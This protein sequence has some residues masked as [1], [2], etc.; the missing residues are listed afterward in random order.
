MSIAVRYRHNPILSP[1]ASDWEARGAFN[2]TVI[3]GD[4]GFHMLYRA[5]STEHH[6]GEHT[7]E[8]SSIGHAI[9][10]DRVHFLNKRQLIVPSESWDLFGC[11]DP[12]VTRIESTYY[13]SYTALSA[14]PPHPRGVSVGLATTKDFFSLENKFHLTPFNSKAFT[15]FPEKIRGS[16]AALLTANCDI[17]PSTIGIALAQ[18][19]DDF[20]NHSFW[21]SWYASLSSH[22]LPLLRSTHDHV[23]IGAQPLLTTYGWLLIYSYIRSYNTSHKFFGIEAVLLDHDSPQRIIKH[24]QEPILFPEE[25]YKR[26]GNVANIVFPSGAI[27]HNNT[28]G[29]YYGAADTT[30][31]LATCALDELISSMK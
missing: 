16:Y 29:I 27:I 23:E 12:R 18:S 2:G 4:D 10:F 26:E 19:I 8:V 5:Q 14:W 6:I 13:I 20:S 31:C 30:T 11:E 15:L 22:A 24:T 21:K 25:T 28:V 1:S 17:P 9:S 7:L 3:A